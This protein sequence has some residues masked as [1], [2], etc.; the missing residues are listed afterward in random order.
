M[1]CAMGT[2]CASAYAN[3]FTAQ[4]EAKNMYPYIHGK[5]PIFVRY[6]DDI[7]VIWNGTIAKLT[8]F[9]YELT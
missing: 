6:I 2:I 5:G 3:I 4:F 8:S 1:G 9:T 7:F